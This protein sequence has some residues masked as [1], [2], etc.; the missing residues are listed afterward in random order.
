MFT[1]KVWTDGTRLLQESNLAASSH[2]GHHIT[3][4]RQQWKT[5]EGLAQGSY[6]ADRVG[7]EPVTFRTKYHHSPTW[8]MLAVTA[9]PHH[10]EGCGRFQ[11]GIKQAV[12]FFTKHAWSYCRFVTFKATPLLGR[13]SCHTATYHWLVKSALGVLD[14]YRDLALEKLW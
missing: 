4:Y 7:F 3:S 5:S 6:V 1:R 9:C 8:L 12:D 2:T 10:K 14:C 11:H 13:L